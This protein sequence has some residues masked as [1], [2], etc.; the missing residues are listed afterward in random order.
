MQLGH[1]GESGT[2]QR[3]QGLLPARIDEV[4][5]MGIAVYNHVRAQFLQEGEIAFIGIE[6][7]EAVVGFRSG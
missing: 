7:P 4:G 5:I 1:R 3:L 2:K 6:Y